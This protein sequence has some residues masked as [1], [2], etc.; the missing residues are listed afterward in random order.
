MDDA[1]SARVKEDIKSVAGLGEIV[2]SVFRTLQRD[3]ILPP[4]N[5]R[6]SQHFP[7]DE[8]AEKALKGKAISHGV[9]YGQ[10]QI[11]NRNIKE[12]VDVDGPDNPVAVFV[13]KYRSRGREC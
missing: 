12:T 8:V 13:F 4:A 2:I 5:F 10:Q 7:L 1:D 6:T 3:P 11:V 9:V